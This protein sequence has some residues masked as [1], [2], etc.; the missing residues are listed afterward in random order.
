MTTVIFAIYENTP[1]LNY[2]NYQDVAWYTSK[3]TEITNLLKTCN[4]SFPKSIHKVYYYGIAQIEKDKIITI[5]MVMTPTSQRTDINHVELYSICTDQMH[6]KQGH[7]K[8]MIA[9]VLKYFKQ[10][11]KYAWI[12]IDINHSETYFKSLVKMYSQVG[13][14][15]YPTYGTAT[16]LGV[17]FHTGFVQLIAPLGKYDG[18]IAKI[19]NPHTIKMAWKCARLKATPQNMRIYS[20]VMDNVYKKY[21]HFPY[22]YGGPMLFQTSLPT[23]E[24]DKLLPI[25]TVTDVNLATLAK[26]DERTMSVYTPPGLYLFHTHPTPAIQ[27]L[28]SV[29]AWPSTGDVDFC[30]FSS[31]Y[32][33]PKLQC[34]FVLSCEGFYIMHMNE[35]ARAILQKFNNNQY[36]IFKDK[37]INYLNEKS[38]ENQR[39][40]WT[41]YFEEL[42]WKVHVVAKEP[43]NFKSWIIQFTSPLGRVYTS[44]K[45]AVSSPEY[46]HDKRHFITF[47]HK[48]LNQQVKKM[49][50]IIGVSM[51]KFLPSYTDSDEVLMKKFNEGIPVVYINYVPYSFKTPIHQ[52]VYNSNANVRVPELRY[53]NRPVSATRKKYVKKTPVQHKRTPIRR[54]TTPPILKKTPKLVKKM[55]PR[56]R[57]I[58]DMDIDIKSLK[59]LKQLK[60]LEP[61]K[62]IHDM[63]ID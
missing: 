11:Y 24:T 44:L 33:K 59:P 12:A 58:H 7:A 52:I 17:E 38:W 13:F 3:K 61:K 56:P 26:G 1:K 54:K 55:V 43:D 6:R 15:Y 16:P 29:F 45:D 4:F 47:M 30:L 14:Q 2:P 49:S 62:K 5:G 32:S 42:G 34:S 28:K 53:L 50:E 22:E 36:A 41:V 27:L 21:G 60:P 25:E 9:N 40:L 63:D 39:Y 57:R 31:V 18:Q 8:V 51:N 46:T 23:S 10:R 35:Y 37:Y 20:N 48:R 19:V